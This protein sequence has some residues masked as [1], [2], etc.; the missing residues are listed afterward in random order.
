M[1]GLSFTLISGRRQT[2]GQDS[3]LPSQFNG[4]GASS[5]KLYDCEALHAAFLTAK[6]A[7]S[8]LTKCRS[9][10]SGHIRSEYI[11]HK[12]GACDDD[13]YSAGG[14]SCCVGGAGKMRPRHPAADSPMRPDGPDKPA[15]R[16]RDCSPNLRDK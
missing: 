10:L 3:V 5:L 9:E 13:D 11:S 7:I 4:F 16:V 8:T 12:Q 15:E 14:A 1:W 2:A 6:H